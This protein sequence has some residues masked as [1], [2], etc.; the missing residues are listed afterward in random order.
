MTPAEYLRMWLLVMGEGR[1][2]IFEK[3]REGMERLLEMI[4][5][6]R[7]ARPE[8]RRELEDLLRSHGIDPATAGQ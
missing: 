5:E 7:D 4:Q 1:E 2:E 3:L 8:E 6:R